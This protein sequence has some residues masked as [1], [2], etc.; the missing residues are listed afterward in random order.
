MT[1]PHP[2]AVGSLGREFVA[3]AEARSG[4]PLRWW[5]RLVA[6]R[7][8]ETDDQERL[9]WETLILTMAR[10]LGKS[11]LLRE[12]L[13][14]RMQQQPRFG[15]PQDVLHTGK[16]LAVCKEVQRPARLWAKAHTDIY[17]VR[18][19]NG[20][21]EIE[22]LADGE[23]VSEALELFP[24]E[25]L[26]ID[27]AQVDLAVARLRAAFGASAV[28]GAELRD[29]HR[30]EAAWAQTAFAPVAAGNATAAAKKPASIRHHASSASRPGPGRSPRRTAASHKAQ[31]AAAGLEAQPAAAARREAQPT[32]AARRK[33]QPEAA[34]RKAQPPRIIPVVARGGAEA[35][36]LLPTPVVVPAETDGNIADA[37]PPRPPR[38]AWL[39]GVRHEVTWASS[40]TRL[41]GEWWTDEPLARDYFEIGT[42][43]GGRYWLYRD[44]ADGRFYLH[45]V[46]D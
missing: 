30:P 41:E 45:G 11:W 1:A 5:Q 10:Q 4:R 23:A 28:H 12:L 19:V 15:E 37:D 26:P 7:L 38:A 6:T 14:W 20:Q 44:H 27:P 36:R 16:D 8:L 13:L 46:F 33:T 29:R 35:L 25:A 3:A 22:V 39:E 21:E 42:D 32:A 24:R 34:G 17:R 40:P 9:V 2:A 31:P 43:D 18:E